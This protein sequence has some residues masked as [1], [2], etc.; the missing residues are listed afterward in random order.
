MKTSFRNLAVMSLSLVAISSLTGCGGGGAAAPVVIATDLATAYTVTTLGAPTGQFGMEF[1]AISPDG[2][3]I[4][5][6][7][8]DGTYR[9]VFRYVNGGIQVVS[10]ADQYIHPNNVSD[11]GVIAAT[12]DTPTAQAAC[13]I[14]GNSA[15]IFP[16]GDHEVDGY[17][18][19]ADSSGAIYRTA[20]LDD[21]SYRS[22]RTQGNTSTPITV[23]GNENFGIS[24]VSPSGWILGWSNSEFKAY[25]PIAKTW[26]TVLSGQSNISARSIGNDGTI[27][28]NQKVG[29]NW[30]SFISN[31]SGLTN[32]A[33]STS[34]YAT[35][36]S[37]SSGG[38][39]AGSDNIF[40]GN[41]QT[42]H[43]F[44]WSQ[45][46][47]YVDLNTRISE[48]NFVFSRAYGISSNGTIVGYGIKNGTAVA[49]ILTPVTR[50]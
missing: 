14:A 42:Y 10:P 13:M 31:G 19:S 25:D 15:T 28:G 12:A 17:S 11:S 35:L 5:G 9:M 32:Y 44:A 29:A 20:R 50:N 2:K 40:D 1:D 22:Y 41:I 36:G 27:I 4:V 48:P 8:T 7:Y 18:G 38:I 21:G 6:S 47:G 49:C 45:A 39:A 3:Q 30:V 26:S 37:I 43:A 46:S 24:S 23:D 16:Y 33:D 34:T